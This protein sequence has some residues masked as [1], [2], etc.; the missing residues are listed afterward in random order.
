[1]YA[2]KKKEKKKKLCQ[3]QRQLGNC[4]KRQSLHCLIYYL[5]GDFSVLLCAKKTE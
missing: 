5:A 1:M 3:K 2:L 4:F